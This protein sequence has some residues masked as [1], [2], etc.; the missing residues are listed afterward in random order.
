MGCAPDTR[1]SYAAEAEVRR[2]ARRLIKFAIAVGLVVCS[3]VT[4]NAADQRLAQL[5]KGYQDCVY[6]AVASQIKAGQTNNVSATVEVAFQSCATEEAAIRAHVSAA[7]V[8]SVDTNQ[9][10]QVLSSA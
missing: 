3:C 6:D 9:Q 5:R 8:S 10:L 2:C 4:G 7:G 1:R